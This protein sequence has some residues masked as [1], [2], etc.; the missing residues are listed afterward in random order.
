VR[1][2]LTRGCEELVQRG[3]CLVHGREHEARKEAA[4]PHRAVYRDPRWKRCRRIALQRAGYRC[5]VVEHGARCDV[6]DPSGRVLHAHHHPLGVQE[7]LAAGL[8]PFD[9]ERV[10]IACAWHHGRIEAELRRAK[11]QS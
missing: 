9:P 11:R 8:S 2:C 6:V 10:V 4:A 3:R 1:P 7:L 5:Q